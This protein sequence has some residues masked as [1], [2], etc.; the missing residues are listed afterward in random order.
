[1]EKN[2]PKCVGVI[3]DGNRRWA[4]GKG[5]D[6][7]IGHKFGYEKLKET[8][9]WAKEAGIK[10]MIAYALS[11]EN[12]KRPEQE[13]SFLLDIFRFVLSH[14]IERL[15]K[16]KVSVRFIGDVSRFPKDIREGIEKA[17]KETVQNSDFTLVLAVSYG[18]RAEIIDGIKKI[19]AEKIS[20]KDISEENLGDFL[21]TKGIADPDLIIRTGGEIRLSNFLPWQSIYSELFFT[22]TLWPD[23]SREEF[24]KILEEFSH[25][26]RN[27]GK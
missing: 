7:W 19:I 3:M 13:L 24:G 11:T 6:P 12:W 8:L 18:G 16:D 15:K 2:I 27:L 17:E 5:E 4:K 20:A 14:E 10:T 25:R 22:K 21:W 1:M 26:K 9:M 23:F